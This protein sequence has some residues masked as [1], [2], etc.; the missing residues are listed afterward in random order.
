MGH[1]LIVLYNAALIEG[2]V[3]VFFLFHKQ[4]SFPFDY[5]KY[6]TRK[7]FL[8]NG[9]VLVRL[10]SYYLKQN[11]DR[12]V[13]DELFWITP[14]RFLLFFMIVCLVTYYFLV[15][16]REL[17]GRKLSPFLNRFLIGLLFVAALFWGF[18][19]TMSYVEGSSHLL[20][21]ANT[22][23]NALGLVMILCALV[24]LLVEGY[25]MPDESAKK[26]ALS[27]GYPYVFL[28]ITA[29]LLMVFPN[30]YDI[31]LLAVLFIF[32]NTFH[33]LWYIFCFQKG[34]G[35]LSPVAINPATIL[36]AI[37]EYQLS[38]REGEVFRLLLE[39]KENKEIG[40]LLFISVN[41][42]RNHVH[43]IFRKLD[44]GSRR[45]LFRKCQP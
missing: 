1:V 2:L 34:Y 30:P 28:V 15:I 17:L 18:A 13:T 44:V 22:V 32:I 27:Y 31:H 24:H 43:S 26:I 14:V 33:Y 11:V 16:T 19:I 10:V 3:V 7:L 8:I 23:T 29:L 42:V 41:T 35:Q 40:D 5:L 4:R 12:S 36:K 39:G 37:E 6:I 45:Q 21:V 38:R 20:F 25:N 9:Y